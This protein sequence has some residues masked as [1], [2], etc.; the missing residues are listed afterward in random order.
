MIRIYNASGGI[1]QQIYI[2]ENDNTY[3]DL[4]KYIKLPKHPLFDE[5]NKNKN[6]L[7]INNIYVETIPVLSNI[8]GEVNMNDNINEDELYIGFK[9]KYFSVMLLPLYRT[10]HNTCNLHYI[11]I[12]S[13]ISDTDI[14]IDNYDKLKNIILIDPYQLI[15]IEPNYKNYHELCLIVV[16]Q[17]QYMIKYICDKLQTEE[18]CKLTVQ[19][20]ISALEYVK[21]KTDKQINIYNKMVSL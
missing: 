4:I 9:Y 6:I 17:K 14:N 10:T 1:H 8:L 5:F 12:R 15:F 2:T 13:I 20:N 18:I 7:S 11:E 3:N 19:Q 16:Q 21:I